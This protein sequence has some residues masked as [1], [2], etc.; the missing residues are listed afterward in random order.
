MVRITTLLALV[1]AA[2]QSWASAGSERMAAPASRGVVNIYSHRHYEIDEQLY[3]AFTAATG[4]KVNVVQAEANELMERLKAEGNRSPA[5]LL[6]AEDV[7]RLLRAVAAGLVQPVRSP[8]LEEAIPATLRDPEGRWF[9]LT[10]RAR[11]VAYSRDRV[12]P[13]DLSTY[14]DLASPRWKGRLLVRSST[15]I[16]NQSL[17]AWMIASRGQEAAT[18]WAAGIVANLA[19]APKGSDRDQVAAIAA[20]EGDIALVNTYYV[21][22]LSASANPAERSAAAAVAIHFPPDTHVNVSGAAVTAAAPNRDNAIAL[23]EYLVS[24]D[25]QGLFA[26]ANYE[27]PVRPG[28]PLAPL[29]A[30]WGAFDASRLPLAAINPWYEQAYKIFDEVGWR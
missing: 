13:S 23:L 12:R 24:Q 1:L 11:I 26:Q 14:D 2:A 10:R 22:L 18:R 17:L 27:Y 30:S 3:A 25:A 7:G 21:G 6:I 8:R 16:Y 15:S 28:V 19:R 4:I 20:G 29:L 5:D 9:G